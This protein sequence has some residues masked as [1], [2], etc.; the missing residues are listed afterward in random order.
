MGSVQQELAALEA[1]DKS[2]TEPIHNSLVL[3]E[4]KIHQYIT[5]ELMN[6]GSRS[7]MI[8]NWF[9]IFIN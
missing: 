9:Y 5:M 8:T 7:M 2:R 4:L 3:F 1:A 6:H